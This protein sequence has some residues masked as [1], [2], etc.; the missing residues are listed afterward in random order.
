MIRNH[1]PIYT[2]KLVEELKRRGEWIPKSILKTRQMGEE[3][4]RRFQQYEDE[5]AAKAPMYFI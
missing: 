2:D 3:L 1:Y 4:K 5:Q